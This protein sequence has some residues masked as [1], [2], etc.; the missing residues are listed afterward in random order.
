MLGDDLPHVRTRRSLK[1]THIAPAKIHTVVPD[2]AA[3]FEIVADDTTDATA[4][5]QLRFQFG[6]TNRSDVFVDVQIIG[7]DL[8]LTRSFVLRDFDG[9]E[10]M[11]HCISNLACALLRSLITE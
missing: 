7:Y 8:L 5:G 2:V 10:R 11:R 4:D 3:A 6:M 9:R 1:G